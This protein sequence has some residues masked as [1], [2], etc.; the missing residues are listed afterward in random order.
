MTV[1]MALLSL[2]AAVLLFGLSGLIGKSVSSPPVVVTCLRSLIGAVA[3]GAFLRLMSR[4]HELLDGVR[5]RIKVMLVGGGLLAVHWW[6]FFMAIRLGTVS[7]GLL[8]YASFPLFITVLNWVLQREPVHRKDWWAAG[9]V[10]V[11]LGLVVPDW[12]FG[13]QVGLAS[14]LGLV[15]GLT[16]A[17]LTLLN[18]QL[19]VHVMP[20]P[21]VTVQMAIAG[22]VLLPLAVP[23]FPNV[24]ASDWLRLLL[25][26]VAC[27][28]VAHAIF[29]SSL[30]TVR[31]ASVSVAASLEPVYGMLAAWMVLGESATSVMLVGAAFVVGASF[32]SMLP[33][34][35][36]KNPKP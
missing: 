13:S 21:L 18:R 22:L 20:L 12:N 15:S 2:H 11:G 28:G 17:L 35:A 5:G 26:G 7:L 10:L 34:P 29:T 31:V 32:L 27:T 30:R 24:Q 25:L 1:R 16:F 23:Q 6:T 14:A 33:D 19:T 8:T 9:T 3:L 4:G 36:M